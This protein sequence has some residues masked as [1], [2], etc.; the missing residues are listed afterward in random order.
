MDSVSEV[1]RDVTGALVAALGGRADQSTVD[2][3]VAARM[4]GN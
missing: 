4:K 2:D 1:A 3:A